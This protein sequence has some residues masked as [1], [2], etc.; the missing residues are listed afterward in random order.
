MPPG[1]SDL[2][3]RPDSEAE[4]QDAGIPAAVPLPPPV[5]CGD[6]PESPPD[7]GASPADG[8]KC[9]WS[10]S[11]AITVAPSDDDGPSDDDDDDGDDSDGG[12]EGWP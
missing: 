8:S 11:D 6:G 5:G 9:G 4:R 7:K 1:W 12:S 10:C 3:R 2:A